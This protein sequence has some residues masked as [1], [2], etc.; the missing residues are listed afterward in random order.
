MTT[1]IIIT[2][3]V[4]LL[5]AYAFDLTSKRTRIPSVILLMALGFGLRQATEALG[6]VV[7]DLAPFLP[8]FGTVGLILIVME[9]ALELEVD[10]SK[11]PFIAITGIAALLPLAALSF[12]LAAVF[13]SVAGVPMWTA[14]ANAIPL[15]VIS[16]AVAIPSAQAFSRQN[17]E[18]VVYESSLSDIIGVIAF[19]FVTLNDNF[20]YGSVMEFV[21][22]FIVMIVLSFAASIGLAALLGRIQ[23]RVKY[24]PITVAV[25]L[26][27][28]IA[29]EY[30]LPAL[31]F[32]LMFGLFLGNLD[33]IRGLPRLRF[34][35]LGSLEAE[36]ER[37]HEMAG[38]VTFLIRAL[39]F[40]LF[41]F[42]ITPA[43]VLDVPSLAW[44]AGIVAG[45]F[46]LRAITLLV[47]RQPLRPLL[48]IAPRGLITILLFLSL[49]ADHVVPMMG[50][51]LIIQVII[52][53]ALVMMI[54]TMSTARERG[55][56]V[57]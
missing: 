5:I 7:P 45:I 20:T 40:L 24:L 23:H 31:I 28:A 36:T 27:Y 48:F 18:F 53:C 38:E 54:G 2:L 1:P 49:S 56:A 4:T 39:F 14:L 10:R 9:G 11:L 19:N 15:A 32:I 34:L 37:F 29:K 17:K 35:A 55:T 50:R 26:I 21:L 30:H 44:T 46:A 6:I 47:L 16:S 13:A 42:V 43:E 33:R 12:G 51:P 8:F 41:G 25:V 52:A 3:C 22:E 57:D